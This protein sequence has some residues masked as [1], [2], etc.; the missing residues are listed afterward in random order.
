MAPVARRRRV[1][2]GSVP[3]SLIREQPALLIV[4]SW[5]VHLRLVGLLLVRLLLILWGGA[6]AA[7]AKILLLGNVLRI[8]DPARSARSRIALVARAAVRR[9]DVA[10]IPTPH[11]LRCALRGRQLLRRQING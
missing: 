3:G 4:R 2:L 1:E 5:R 10:I 6:I 7:L 9:V 11:R 8:V